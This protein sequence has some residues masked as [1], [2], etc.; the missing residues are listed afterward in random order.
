MDPHRTAVLRDDAVLHVEAL[1][2]LVR[3][4]VLRVDAI[5]VLRV[6]VLRPEV[7]APAPFLRVVAEQ[8]ADLR[9]DVELLRA[10]VEG[11]AVRDGWDVLHEGAEPVLRFSQARFDLLLSCDVDH[12]ALPKRSR[13]VVVGDDDGLVV[14]P[15]RA[16][17]LRHHPVFLA[18]REALVRRPVALR[19]HAVEVVGVHDPGEESGLRPPRL[20]RVAE[21]RLDLR[22]DVHHRFLRVVHVARE[23]LI[24]DRRGPLDEPPEPL[25]GGDELSLTLL[26]LADI[27]EHAVGVAP[28]VG[29]LRDRRGVEDP[30]LAAVA[31][32]HP[33]LGVQ[34]RAVLVVPPIGGEGRVPVVGM[35]ERRPHRRIAAPLRG[36]V[37]EE[38]LDLRAD[39]DGG[40]R[41]ARVLA[42]DVDVRGGR[43][44]FDE[45]AVAL[46]GLLEVVV[47]IGTGDRCADQIGGGT[48]RLELRRVPTG[49]GPADAEAAPRSVLRDD[50]EGGRV[51]VIPGGNGAAPLPAR[52]LDR[53][54]AIRAV[55]E[56]HDLIRARSDSDLLED[57]AERLRQVRRGE[58][59][60]GSGDHGS[61]QLGGVRPCLDG[62]ALWGAHS[63]PYRVLGVPG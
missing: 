14:E 25:L 35:H 44:L 17:V 23:F 55:F 62:R 34:R 9:A 13:P 28:A 52:A 48:E 30:H 24:G 29:P 18:V 41:A 56:E 22:A 40:P 59:P 57:L 10:R 39:V 1:A 15:D 36:G 19:E 50:V 43:D 38:P 54:G 53:P 6:D 21:D 60:A 26:A 8:V 2:G 51:G 3:P 16:A 32:P 4:L 42:L 46:A 7:L 27:G 58:Q 20:R 5:S 11:L 33:V 45:P 63:L 49:R 12:D 61:E 47:P 37:A 31:R